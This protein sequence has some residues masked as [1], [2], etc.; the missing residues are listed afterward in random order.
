[1]VQLWL[2]EKTFITLVQ[3]LTEQVVVKCIGNKQTCRTGDLKT[4]S[5]LTAVFSCIND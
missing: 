2:V 1:M 4:L 5:S 3:G